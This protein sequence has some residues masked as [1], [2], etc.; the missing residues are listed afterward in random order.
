MVSGQRPHLD[1][2]DSLK[3]KQ[4]FLN[5]FFQSKHPFQ[6][7]DISEVRRMACETFK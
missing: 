4:F 2:W 7:F 1:V 6:R 3:K 5:I